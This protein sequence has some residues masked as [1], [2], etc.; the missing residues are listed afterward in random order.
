MQERK[1]YNPIQKDY[2]TF[3]EMSHETDDKHTLLEVDLAPNGGVGLHYHHHYTE[4]FEVIEG[5]LGLQI[6]K[7]ILHLKVGETASAN[8]HEKHRF[9]NDTQTYCKFRCIVKPAF[10]GFEEVLQIGYG[11][12]RD[13]KTNAKG[14]PKNRLVLAYLVWL[15]EVHLTGWRAWMEPF[16][17]QMAKKAIQKG[18][19]KVL[20][21]QYVKF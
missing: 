11:L 20:R 12:V 9:F 4:S 16:I 18:L 7:K 10:R 21:E 14:L 3:L 17:N 15:G 19:D 1:I 2:V 5:V 13:G 8:I 6:G